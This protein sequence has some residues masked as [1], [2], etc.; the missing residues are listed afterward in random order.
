MNTS[1]VRISWSGDVGGHIA[2]R[3]NAAR[4]RL[5]GIV[6]L[7]LM[8]QLFSGVAEAQGV[9][10]SVERT[11]LLITLSFFVLLV[12]LL[13]GVGIMFFDLTGRREDD[14][15]WLQHKIT[16]ELRRDRGLTVRVR[17]V[18]QAPV[19]MS[20]TVTVELSGEVPSDAARSAVLDS[21]ENAALKLGRDI[22]IE[23]HLAISARAA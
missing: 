17:P 20:S 2:A 1:L 11:A 12:L 9:K 15:A 3:S 10:D 19:G 23:D 6:A 5:M 4:P 21:V 8:V 14:A 18:V 13:V 22:E 7:P 16:N